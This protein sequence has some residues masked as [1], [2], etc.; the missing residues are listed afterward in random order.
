M[1]VWHKAGGV[2]MIPAFP[3]FR[4]GDF[5][6]LLSEISGMSRILFIMLMLRGVCTRKKKKEIGSYPVLEEMG[7]AGSY[8]VYDSRMT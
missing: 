4:L 2:A 7:W 5:S 3:F 6:G 1:G 8:R